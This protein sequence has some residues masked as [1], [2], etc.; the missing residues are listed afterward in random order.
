MKKIIR[1]TMLLA[2]MAATCVSMGSCSSD[3]DAS[4]P[5]L[6]P[7]Q[8][9]VYVPKESVLVQTMKEHPVEGLAYYAGQFVTESNTISG[10]A[11]DWWKIDFY[12]VDDP[13]Y[14]K[15]RGRYQ[16]RYADAYVFGFKN[17][18]E[19]TKATL[20]TGEER[21]A[22]GAWVSFEKTGK[23]DSYE[24]QEYK[25]SLH[26]DELKERNGDYARDINVNSTLF[27]S[28]GN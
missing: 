7:Q 19:Y 17:W 6:P 8:G 20:S 24:A 15:W 18:H 16:I 21:P 28:G 26:F 13:G 23:E 11:E 2:M 1:M 22:S 3:D 27:I 12:L 9:D 14:G 4:E 5:V 25:V 10:T